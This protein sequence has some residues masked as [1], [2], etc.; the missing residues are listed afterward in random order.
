MA[1][2]KIVD[3][4]TS[5]SQISYDA[6]C[7]CSILLRCGAIGKFPRGTS[8]RN[9]PTCQ[10]LCNARRARSQIFCPPRCCAQNRNRLFTLQCTVRSAV[11][12]GS[13]W[14]STHVQ[15]SWVECPLPSIP[16]RF[17]TKR[18]TTAHRETARVPFQQH[19]C[20]GAWGLNLLLLQAPGLHSPRALDGI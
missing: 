18:T 12:F 3:S 1:G 2:E 19:L 6:G 5:L 11:G 4:D 9:P 10:D 7:Y 20:Q 14:N 17:H 16:P 15:V 13:R 8:A